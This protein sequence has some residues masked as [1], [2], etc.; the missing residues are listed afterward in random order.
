MAN[1]KAGGGGAEK[2]VREVRWE[3]IFKKRQMNIWEAEWLTVETDIS[4]ICRDVS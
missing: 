1:M 4:E 2:C 3:N